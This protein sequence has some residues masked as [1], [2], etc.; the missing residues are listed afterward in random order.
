LLGGLANGIGLTLTS[1]CLYSFELQ[2]ILLTF[3]AWLVPLSGILKL[4]LSRTDPTQD[5]NTTPDQGTDLVNSPTQDDA[6]DADPTPYPDETDTFAA[7]PAD[8]PAF[9]TATSYPSSRS[10]L[11]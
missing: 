11:K 2:S 3:L 7:Y 5:P 10:S 9:I 8:D 4:D 1:G 6:S